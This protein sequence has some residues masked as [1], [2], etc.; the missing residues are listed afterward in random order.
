MNR[1]RFLSSLLRMAVLMLLAFILVLAL[2][3]GKTAMLLIFSAMPLATLLESVF[4]EPLMA[5]LDAHYRLDVAMGLMI[6][7]AYLQWTLLGAL[8]AHLWQVF[9]YRRSSS[10]SKADQGK[11]A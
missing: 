1:P 8:L 11:S 9:R 6:V 7:A 4:I 3:R 5:W 2:L 10:R